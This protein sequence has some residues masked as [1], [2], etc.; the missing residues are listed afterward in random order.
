MHLIHTFLY[1]DN[2]ICAKP[3]N[4]LIKIYLEPKVFLNSFLNEMNKKGKGLGNTFELFVTVL[5]HIERKQ[6]DNKTARVA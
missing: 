2:L 6:N 4:F 1:R 3:K 5:Y